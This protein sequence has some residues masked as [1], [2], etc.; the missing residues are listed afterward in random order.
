MKKRIQRK[1]LEALLESI[2]QKNPK[3]LLVI[4]S[5]FEIYLTNF[6]FQHFLSE[7]V[8]GKTSNGKVIS[9]SITATR[10]LIRLAQGDVS[11]IRK[12]SS[13]IRGK[14]PHAFFSAGEFSIGIHNLTRDEIDY[15]LAQKNLKFTYYDN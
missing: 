14:F 5:E 3:G 11:N 6:N 15:C 2:Y 7:V 13:F 10:K 1:K 8:S 12:C 9:D 4:E